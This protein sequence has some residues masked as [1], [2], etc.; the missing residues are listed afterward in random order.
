MFSD[1]GVAVGMLAFLPSSRAP[2]PIMP[3]TAS[4]TI[5]PMAACATTQ[6][7]PEQK[8]RFSSLRPERSTLEGRPLRHRSARGK[9]PSSLFAFKGGMANSGHLAASRHTCADSC[10]TSFMA[11]R[12]T[13][14]SR[15]YSARSLLAMVRL[16]RQAAADRWR[17]MPLSNE[18]P[19]LIRPTP[20]FASASV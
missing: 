5:R 9:G 19:L 8:R 7:V 1:A 10:F 18:C 13:E 15:Y 12:E 3:T 20:G 14:Y 2:R 4:S 6:T 16:P 17:S 11:N